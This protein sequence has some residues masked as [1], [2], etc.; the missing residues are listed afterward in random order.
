MPKVYVILGA[1]GLY[2]FFIAMNWGGSLLSNLAGV[3]LP[4]YYSLQAIETTGTKDDTRLLTYWVSYGILTII[5]YW[6][7]TILYFV[8]FYFLIKTVFL[9]W[10]V[11]PQFAGAELVYAKVL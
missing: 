4:T 10:L 2:V 6:S 11:L 5:E 3:V 1:V 7:N 9:L 8:P